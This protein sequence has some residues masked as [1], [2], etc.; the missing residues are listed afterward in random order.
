MKKGQLTHPDTFGYAVLNDTE[1]YSSANGAIWIGI[2]RYDEIHDPST[3]DIDDLLMD[4]RACRLAVD[5]LP[6]LVRAG[7]MTLGIVPYALSRNELLTEIERCSPNDSAE[8]AMIDA[9]K[10]ALIDE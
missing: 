9:L 7:L 1:T 10:E 2:D 6:L 3:D 4:S 5:A 8:Q